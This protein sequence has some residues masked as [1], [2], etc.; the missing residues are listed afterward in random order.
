[1]AI[2]PK[3]TPVTEKKIKV[4]LYGFDRVGFQPGILTKEI[5]G[6]S[7]SFVRYS[8]TSVRLDSFD[9]VVIPSS[10]FE[11]ISSHKDL[12]DDQ[13]QTAKYDEKNIF[14]RDKQLTNHI[15]EGKWVAFVI[16]SNVD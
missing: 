8:D 13:Y 16:G 9:G 11:T 5:N 7:Y 1:M 15:Q 6:I 2:V 10:I 4:A 12:Y 3:S 14:V